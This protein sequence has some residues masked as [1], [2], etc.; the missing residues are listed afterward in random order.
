MFPYK[1]TQ[2]TVFL[3]GMTLLVGQFAALIHSVEHP[4]HEHTE[5]CKAFSALEKSE[6][7]LIS[8]GLVSID[9]AFLPSFRANLS[10]FLL[11]YLHTSYFI[12]APPT[13][14]L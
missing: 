9:F 4:F 12:R 5:L 3:I 13:F 14:L 8:N 7:S 10:T 6:S 2:L 1:Y 11:T